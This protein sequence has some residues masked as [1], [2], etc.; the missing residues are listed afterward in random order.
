MDQLQSRVDRAR[1]R[2]ARRAFTPPYLGLGAGVA[3][4]LETDPLVVPAKAA[5]I[6]DLERRAATRLFMTLVGDVGDLEPLRPLGLPARPLSY[7]RRAL[8]MQPLHQS[9]PKDWPG[10]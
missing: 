4:V 3:G 5:L 2:N 6:G 8:S 9:A 7:R 10:R 1:N